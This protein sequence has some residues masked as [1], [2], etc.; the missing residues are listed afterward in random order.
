MKI[1]YSIFSLLITIPLFTRCGNNFNICYDVEECHQKGQQLEFEGHT[2]DAL[3]H[4]QIGCNY[5]KL[6]GVEQHPIACDNY[7]RLLNTTQP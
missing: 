7:D 5:E 1:F 6:D 3:N 2:E 4:Y